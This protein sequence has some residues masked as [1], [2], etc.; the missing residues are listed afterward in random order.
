MHG[1]RWLAHM[2]E[3]LRADGDASAF[4]PPEPGWSH[5]ER[6]G[7]RAGAS[8]AH[9][10]LVPELRGHFAAR[11][12]DGVDYPSPRIQGLVAIEMGNLITVDARPADCGGMLDPHSLGDDQPHPAL[13][14]A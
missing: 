2:L 13:D 12:V 8:D 3:V 14:P 10:A 1:A 9:G 4:R 11:L 6:L 7:M 5:T